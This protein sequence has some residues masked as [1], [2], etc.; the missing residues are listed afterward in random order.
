MNKN[1]LFFGGLVL[2]AMLGA[3][4]AFALSKTGPIYLLLLNNKSTVTSPTGEIWMNRNL[5]ASRVATSSTDAEAYGDLYQWGRLAD[6]HEKRT[7]STTLTLSTADVPGHGSFIPA[8]SSPY[9]WRTPQNNNLW[10]GISGTNNPCPSG[11]RLPTHTELDAERASWSSDDSAGAFA[12]PLKLVMAG[13]RNHDDGT[14][15]YAGSYGYYWSSTVDGSYSRSLYFSSGNAIM[16]RS[17]RAYGF[18]VRC[19]KD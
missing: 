7:S 16:Y 19:L 8:P 12:S 2:V 11:F 13:S 9:D 4:N 15:S 17:G 5:G 18:S 3:S 1:T 10:Q 14:L 6:G